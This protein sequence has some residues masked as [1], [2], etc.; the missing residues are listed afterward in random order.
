MEQVAFAVPHQASDAKVSVPAL[1]SMTLYPLRLG[2]GMGI[3]PHAKGP[4]LILMVLPSVFEQ[5]HPVMVSQVTKHLPSTV[6]K[7]PEFPERTEQ[8]RGTA[9]FV[10][11]LPEL[12]LPPPLRAAT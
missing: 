4:P 1:T 9:D 3:A 6:L 2:A 11:E 5:F 10:S 7:F 8:L 12:Q